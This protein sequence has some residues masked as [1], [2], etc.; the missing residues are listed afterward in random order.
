MVDAGIMKG[1]FKIYNEQVHTLCRHFTPPTLLYLLERYG[2][3][4]WGSGYS[5][6]AEKK[7]EKKNKNLKRAGSR[8][9]VRMNR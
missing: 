2:S 9:Q 1:G 4:M 7:S 3:F 6:S 5:E 8:Q